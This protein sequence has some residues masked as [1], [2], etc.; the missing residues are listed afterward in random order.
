MADED[1]LFNGLKKEI[2]EKQKVEEQ[3]MADQEGMREE[4]K[5]LLEEQSTAG[6]RE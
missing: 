3:L 1:K 2:Q 5:R 4:T 6:I